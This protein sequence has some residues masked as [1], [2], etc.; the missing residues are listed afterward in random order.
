MLFNRISY[1]KS[2]WDNILKVLG[3][4]FLLLIFY[5]IGCEVLLYGQLLTKYILFNDV[6]FDFLSI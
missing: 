1:G 6:R 5:I 3:T 4:I 2:K